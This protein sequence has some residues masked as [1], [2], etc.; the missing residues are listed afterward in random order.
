MPKVL[1]GGQ[2][3]HDPHEIFRAEMDSKSDSQ[4][5]NLGLTL[6]SVKR[7]Q[8]DMAGRMT[9]LET[10]VASLIT[11]SEF[12]FEHLKKSDEPAPQPKSRVTSS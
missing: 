9:A 3:V 7:S 10:A 2:I 6:G 4:K 11:R 12:L 1:P 5:L 8:E